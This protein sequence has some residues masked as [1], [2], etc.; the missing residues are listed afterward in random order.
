MEGW[1]EQLVVF[2]LLLQIP[3]IHWRPQDWL[4]FTPF[5]NA[6][7]FLLFTCSC[8]RFEI[9]NIFIASFD[10]LCFSSCMS[11]PPP[12]PLG[13]S[14]S[15]DHFEKNSKTWSASGGFGIQCHPLRFQT[16]PSTVAKPSGQTPLGRGP[17]SKHD[18]NLWNQL[19][20]S[21]TSMVT[22]DKHHKHKAMIIIL[23]DKHSKI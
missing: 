19:Q 4:C 9:L 17:D 1:D 10:N 12:P 7:F 15:L 5:K 18:N 16:P 8:A 21:K 13:V 11:Y 14:F 22:Q 6:A 3:S 2:G 23:L 20:S